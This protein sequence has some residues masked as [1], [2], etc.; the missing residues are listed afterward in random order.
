MLKIFQSTLPQSIKFEGIG[1]H[2]GKKSKILVHPSTD[3]TGIVFKR[4][5]LEK[6]T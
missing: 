4:T 1:L 5:D 6:I 2:T 3:D